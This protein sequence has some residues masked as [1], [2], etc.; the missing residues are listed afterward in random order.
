M[1]LSGLLGQ[2]GLGDVTLGSLLTD[3]G[4]SGDKLGDLLAGLSNP[5]TSLGGLLNLLG[6]DGLGTGDGITVALTQVLSG[7]G[8]DTNVDLNSL[9]LS[10]VLGDFG[11]NSPLSDISGLSLSSILES[12]GVDL[13]SAETLGDTTLTSLL[14]DLGLGTLGLGNL[15]SD[16]GTALGGS[17]ESVVNTLFAIPGVEN[18]LNEVNLGELTTGLTLG[19]G[20][21]LSLDTLLGDLGVNLPSGTDLSSIDISDVLTS[22]GI[23]PPG[24]LSIGTLL[25]DLGF[26]PATSDLT[27]GGLLTDLGDP[28]GSLSIT[29]LLDNLT[30][31]GLVGDL[32]LSNLELD[33]T[34]VAGELPT[35]TLGDL[36]GDLGLGDLASVS[37]E[38]LGGFDTLLV[39]LVP[40]QIL[41][42]DVVGAPSGVGLHRRARAHQV[43]VAVGAVDAAHRRPHLGPE[44]LA[45]RVRGDL[46]GVRVLPLVD[47]QALGGVRRAAQRIVV[48]R[49]GRRRR[50]CRSRRGWRS[51]RRRT[52]RPR[53]GFRSRSARPSAC[54]RPGSSWSV[55]GSRSPPSRFA[56]SSTVTPVDLVIGRRSRMHSWAT[57]PFSPV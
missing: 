28:F 17:V 49:P 9:T 18:L 33:L 54:P 53:Q 56:T 45:E 43:A 21:S 4:I 37:V 24:D 23:T 38:P 52:R 34:N 29:G 16:A 44:A 25:G 42:R 31:G 3:L 47:Q 41:A 22:L 30:L 15:L 19:N 12:F 32:G 6:L 26:S 8:L 20:G 36:I 51:S 5:I 10:D 57:M 50:P 48:H 7:L 13:P 46:A 2:L 27:L 35:L 55:R 11:I 14:G 40:Q 1:N 39:D